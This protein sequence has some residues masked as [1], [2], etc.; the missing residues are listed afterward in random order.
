LE[1]YTRD[2]DGYFVVFSTFFTSKSSD[3]YKQQS[4]LDTWSMPTME[5]IR[6]LR[7]LSGKHTLSVKLADIYEASTDS[8]YGYEDKYKK[9]FEKLEYELFHTWSKSL[10]P[11][12][13]I[14][15][16]CEKFEHSHDSVWSNTPK[17]VVSYPT[18]LSALRKSSSVYDIYT[19]PTSKYNY[20]MPTKTIEKLNQVDIQP[21][22]MPVFI[23]HPIEGHVNMLKDFGK[24]VKYPMYGIQFT[25]E[26]L[27]YDTV[28]ELADYYWS[29]IM[30]EFPYLER[31][32]LSGVTFGA[33][34]AY[35]MAIKYPTKVVSLSFFDGAYKYEPKQ[36][37]GRMMKPDLDIEW[38]YQFVSQYGEVKDPKK[39]LLALGQFGY[40]DERI[41]YA[42]SELLATPRFN[43][44]PH[45]IELAAKA[46][47][48]KMK[49]AYLYE[50]TSPLRLPEVLAVYP[51]GT[52]KDYELDYD[53]SK[54]FGGKFTT[55]SVYCD[56]REFFEPANGEQVAIFFNEYL[57]KWS[58]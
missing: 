51:Y 52:R 6:E 33:S 50:P 54:Y 23:I 38:L 28:E 35:E 37:Y 29:L 31:F 39:F 11:R 9:F 42:V 43:F 16:F 10:C 44:H 55:K 49:M 26:A 46:Y 32:H 20:L 57:M 14:D 19:A 12:F 36:P 15:E 18:A 5:R 3:A 30:K 27:K 45:D 34:V 40:F 47:V 58:Y 13:D 56:K 7:R 25:H 8:F 41:K 53:W 22:Y 24:Y 17:W 21:G 1:K 2:F 4:K 48:K